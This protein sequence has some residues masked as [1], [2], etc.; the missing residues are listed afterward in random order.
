MRTYAT[1]TEAEL[2]KADLM[3]VMTVDRSLTELWSVGVA[4]TAREDAERKLRYLDSEYRWL[5]RKRPEITAEWDA[6]RQ[7]L[8]DRIRECEAVLGLGDAAQ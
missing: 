1:P 4:S 3:P 8:L 7:P 6:L 5:A 2:L